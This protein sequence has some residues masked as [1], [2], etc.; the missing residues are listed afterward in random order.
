M[1]EVSIFALLLDGIILVLLVA[2]IVF[3]ARLSLHIKAFRDSRGELESLLKTLADHIHKAETSIGD[4]KENAH[5]ITHDLTTQIEDAQ[6]LYDEMQLI[7]DSSN[8]LAAR[9]EQLVEGSR[10]ARGMG[11][12]PEE[13]DGQASAPPSDS[14]RRKRSGDS[15]TSSSP[16]SINDREFHDHGWDDEGEFTPPSFMREDGIIPGEEESE[17]GSQAERELYEALQKRG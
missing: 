10:V 6:A 13:R 15:S 1:G 14:A 17:F 4:L 16:F 9:M 2:T 11:D 5:E 3:A 8:R 12:R 7:H